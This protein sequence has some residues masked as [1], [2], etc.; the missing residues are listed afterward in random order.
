M[1]MGRERMGEFGPA[2]D[3]HIADDRDDHRADE[4]Q[5][6][7]HA[8]RPHDREQAAEH[9][10]DSGQSSE[11][12]DEKYERVH[13][14]DRCAWSEPEN[15][16]QHPCRRV[17]GDAHVDDDGREQRDD[18]QHIAATPIKTAFE[19]VWQGCDAGTEIERREEQRKQD[20]RE[21]RHPF[22]VAKDESE[23]VSSLRETHEMDSGNVRRE[24]GEAD[25]RPRERVAGEEVM[26]TLA[27]ALTFAAQEA[28]RHAK[29]HDREQVDRDDDPVEVAHGIIHGRG[30]FSENSISLIVGPP[31]ASRMFNRNSRAVTGLNC[32]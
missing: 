19:K 27:A 5:N 6:R 7:L 9:R 2:A 24:H 14:Q 28:R 31:L 29:A 17:E 22:K 16:A 20:Q 13:A 25:D 8:F 26:S 18:R 11:D 32:F 21:A 1:R 3:L 15:A 23:L 30:Y 10:V 12:D 4:Q